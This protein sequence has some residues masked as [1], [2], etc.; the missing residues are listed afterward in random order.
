M[1][2]GAHGE[3][4]EGRFN[5]SAWALRHRTLVLF[6]I[7]ALTLAGAFAY[8]ALGRAED[9]PFTFKIM[10]ITAAWP[11]ATAEAMSLQVTDK[12]EKKLQD[13]PYFDYTQSYTRP[14]ETTIM[15]FLKDNTP[16]RQVPD[17]WY[18]VRKSIGDIQR[19]LPSGLIGPFFNDEFGDTFGTIYA[20]TGEGYSKAE[21]K[22]IVEDV[23]QRLL[24]VQHVGKIELLGV[25]DE[26]VYIE[27]SHRR[28]ATLGLSPLQVIDVLQKQNVISSA[29]VVETP[30]T[31]IPV[32]VSGDFDAVEQI[33]WLPIQ[34]GGRSFRLG[35][36]AEVHRGYRDP[37]SLMMRHNGEPVIGLAVSMAKQGNNLEMGT[38]LDAALAK[39]RTELPVGVEINRVADQPKVVERSFEEFIQ[40][41][42]EALAIVLAVSFLTLGLRTGVV[43]ALSVPLVLAMTFCVM[44]AAGIPF[45]RISLGALIIALGLLVDDAIIAV[46][47]MAV[48]LSQGMERAKAAAFA[49]TSTAFPMLSGTLIT[50]A[51][52]VPV[53]F[54]NSA[55]GEYTNAIFWVTFI[56]LVL[57]WIVAVV[58]TPYLGYTL[59]PRP[60][61]GGH[62]EVYDSRLYRTLRAVVAW[63][64]R[65]RKTVV[66]ATLL[67]FVGSIAAFRFVP[68]QFFPSSSRPELLIDLRLPEGS[69][70]QAAGDAAK[71][72][73]QI[74]AG[75]PNVLYYTT[76]VG[77]G[78]PRFYLPLNA[79]LPAA[80]FAQIVVMT[81]GNKEREAVYEKAQQ[82]FLEGF[83]EVRGRVNRLENGP[84]VGYPVQFRVMGN[85]PQKLR[86][87]AADVAGKM[88]TN[89]DVRDVNLQWNELTKVVKL[90]VDYDKARA[91]GLDLSDLSLT[92]NMVLSG[93]PVSQFR[94][95]TETIDIVARAVAAER[96]GL[97]D[98]RNINVR[99][100][101]GGTITLDQVAQLR[102][103]LE[104]PIL[105]RRN[106]D[107]MLVV[108]SDVAEGVQAPTV[109]QALAPAME[110]LRAR[111]PDG[112]RIE[113]GGTIEE[114]AK[115]NGSIFA[116]MPVMV[117]IMLT[118]LMVQLQSFSKVALVFLTAPLGMIGVCAALL[119]S[120]RPFGFVALLGTIA[121]AGMIMR[122]SVILVDQIGQDIRAG[123]HAWD[124]II[125]A[126]VRRARPICLTAA[127]A[128]LAMIPLSMSDFWGPM[129]VAIM[130][131]LAVATLLTL[132]FL[133]A[134]Y[135]A[136]FR[137]K[138]PAG[139]NARPQV[140]PDDGMMLAA[141]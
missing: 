16:P 119:I 29:G 30:T 96:A 110:E 126:T 37:P 24:K 107:L 23:R 17:S 94:E 118:I 125:E 66:L 9:P 49:Y 88:R 140:T 123:Q 45:H 62:H 6:F 4:H 132:L 77:G 53:G 84:P 46:E 106:R 35:D 38:A 98:L 92:L 99:T 70:I 40:A 52:F 27:F 8:K 69:S 48:K 2:A 130:G 138:R 63:C 31:R 129:A 34:A 76:Y 59:L 114:S 21:L 11:G 117:L 102:F 100:A 73:E 33:R 78:S 83:P 57:S 93:I 64:V 79:E 28:I 111:L 122:N 91:L 133:P 44:L 95:G 108:R 134:L 14:G 12:L 97:G 112:Y 120:G 141:E 90:D 127:A 42:G 85:D 105:W 60:K 25:Q 61:A 10:V 3:E 19:T 81:K 74:I 103:A 54:A 131:G 7:I 26:R 80:N 139:H 89:P 121:L 5:L 67:I 20:F 137:V 41:L 22:K 47:M 51:G 116:L 109:S 124:A 128:I 1:S 72:M 56:A 87:I 43:V 15:V 58:F 55:A 82:A 68:Q 65:W 101:T 36:V 71:R 13:V 39:I 32:R 50:A 113:A 18:Q 75:D 104:E 115:G 86:N 135:A 136:W